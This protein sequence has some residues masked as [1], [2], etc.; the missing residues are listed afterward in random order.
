ML[1]MPVNSETD[2][3]V[4]PRTRARADELSAWLPAAAA[5]TTVRRNDGV[6]AD[7]PCTVLAASGFG[8]LAAAASG[9]GTAIRPEQPVAYPGIRENSASKINASKNSASKNSNPAY[10]H[11]ARLAA[12]SGGAPGPH[13]ARDPV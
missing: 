13:P 10:Q 11:S 7:R 6:L 12:F 2:G 1:S 3:T 9:P 8:V 5:M 4:H